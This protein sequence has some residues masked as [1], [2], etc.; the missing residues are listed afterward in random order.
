MALLTPSR[1]RGCAILFFSAAVATAQTTNQA[2]AARAET[3]FERAERD[4]AAH[5]TNSAAAIELGRATYNF[6]LLATNS[7]RHAAIARTGIAACEELIAR[8]PQSAAG[9]YYLAI[10]SGELAD[11]LAPSLTAYK[12]VKEIER[13]FKKAAELDETYDHAGPVRCLGLLYRQAPG[14]PLSIGSKRKAREYLERAAAL[15][16]DFPENILNLVE[17]EVRWH[18][19]AAAEKDLKKLAAL[20]P[21]AKAKLAGERWEP[22]WDDWT[23]RRAAVEAE[24]QKAFKRAPDVP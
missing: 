17:S 12:L 13:E 8:D 9:H 3:A 24:F 22:D 7:A 5:R 11:A 20:W 6:A 4:F 23:T 10:D 2:F 15:A 21:V 14:W 19:A 18:E 1:A 16:P